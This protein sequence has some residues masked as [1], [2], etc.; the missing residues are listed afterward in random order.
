MAFLPSS[1]EKYVF[2]LMASSMLMVCKK[3]HQVR[4]FE[5]GHHEEDSPKSEQ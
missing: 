4:A 5:I 1:L 2:K 3:C